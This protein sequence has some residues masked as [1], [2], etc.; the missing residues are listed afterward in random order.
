MTAN[1]NYHTFIDSDGLL[2]EVLKH[3]D[4]I[5]YETLTNILTVIEER[6]NITA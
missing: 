2:A 1:V 6:N 3:G 5:L 4:K